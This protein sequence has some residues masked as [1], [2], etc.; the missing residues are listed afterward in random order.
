MIS[1]VFDFDNFTLAPPEGHHHVDGG[2]HMEGNGDHSAVTSGHYHVYLD[3]DDDEADHATA[4]TETL[5][6]ELP[7]ELEPG[8]HEIRISLRAPDH[9]AVGVEDTVTIEVVAD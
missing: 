3:T 7:A 5:D 4:W 8:S 9:H 1:L 2:D 6:F